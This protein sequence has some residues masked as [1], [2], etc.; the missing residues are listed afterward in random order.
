MGI[1]YADFISDLEIERAVLKRVDNYSYR[2]GDHLGGGTKESLCLLPELS[3]DPRN[4]TGTQLVDLEF[5]N[6]LPME[7]RGFRPRY[8]TK[9]I[10]IHG[11]FIVFEKLGLS[12]PEADSNIRTILI[13][14][15]P[16][17]CPDKRAFDYDGKALEEF[18]TN[19]L[20]AGNKMTDFEKA[21][22][23]IMERNILLRH[24]VWVLAWSETSTRIRIWF[25]MSEECAKHL[26][27]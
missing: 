2:V 10:V 7:H 22:L 19:F 11:L 25:A 13:H 8:E 21:V 9:R 15:V 27:S 14:N 23:D 4:S 1:K 24:A 18:K 12:P 6:D 3:F 16:N 20:V 17:G 5:E 26:I